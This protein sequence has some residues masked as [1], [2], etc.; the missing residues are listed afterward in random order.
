MNPYTL[1]RPILY[2]FDAESTH[3][4]V[5]SGL[6]HLS[7]SP[8]LLELATRVEQFDDRRLQVDLFGRHFA[9]PLA[10]AAGMDK[11]AVAIPAL[12]AFGFAYVEIGTVTPKPQPGNPK[13]RVFRLPE[14]H[15][16]INRMGF[17]GPGMDAVAVNLH[18]MGGRGVFALNVGPNK[19]RVEHASEDCL[20]VISRLVEFE[21]HY[22]VVNVSSPNTQKLRTLQ[23]KEALHRLLLEVIEG[24]PAASSSIPLLVKIAPDLTE[25]ELDEIVQV[26]TDLSLPGIV[27]TNTSLSR[28]DGLHG[29]VSGEQGGLSGRPL[30]E[31][32]TRIIARIHHITNGK[33][34]IIAAGGVFNGADALDKIGAGATIV[35]TYTGMVYEGPGMAKRVKRQMAHAL[36]KQGIASLNAICGTGYRAVR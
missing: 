29:D 11:H 26:V 21:P 34:T 14:D 13:P 36:D 20:A 33:L 16:L 30:R 12:S 9:S 31:H 27:A 23:G 24:R 28:P 18:A 10:I 5:M 19:E 1:V 17:P 3:D 35:Q 22:I 8:K 2:R 7:D 15:A 6:H 25:R 32:A 4:R